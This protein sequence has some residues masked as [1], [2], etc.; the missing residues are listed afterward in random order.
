MLLKYAS[1]SES[2]GQIEKTHCT[3]T[4]IINTN[5]YKYERAD[6][7]TITRIAVILYNNSV[8]T[9]TKFT[10]SE[11]LF[12][13]TNNKDPHEISRQALFSDAGNNMLKAAKQQTVKNNTKSAP[14]QLV[15]NQAVF[16]K[17]NIRTKMQPRATKVIIKNVAD[18]TFAKC[19]RWKETQTKNQKDEISSELNEIILHA[20]IV[21]ILF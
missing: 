13:N 7:K 20:L 21:F 18:R 17:T 2:N 15:E 9:A 12:N 11:L 8:H 16:V 19:Q 14:P 6:T 4:E 10:P 3:I 5:K 1:C